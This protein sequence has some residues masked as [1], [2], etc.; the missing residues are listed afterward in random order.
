MKEQIQE[1]QDNNI[2]RWIKSEIKKIRRN[3]LFAALPTDSRLNF[4]TFA[5]YNAL[6]ARLQALYELRA[7]LN[8]NY[9]V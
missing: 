2:K 3:D 4:A 6:I 9:N 1:A 8:R 7:I 5:E